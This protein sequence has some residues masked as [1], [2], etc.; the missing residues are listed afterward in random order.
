MN[1]H[2]LN[3]RSE[4]FIDDSLDSVDKRCFFLMCGKQPN[5]DSA[6]TID[7]SFNIFD[8]PG[9]KK[10]VTLA[11]C[12]DQIIIEYCNE[13]LK[14]LTDLG[15][16]YKL[17]F[18]YSDLKKAKGPSKKNKKRGLQTTIQYQT[19]LYTIRKLLLK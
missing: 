19:P 16:Q 18:N 2:Y 9:L 6:I 4:I 14:S 5:I 1:N 13:I 3:Q 8:E 17:A 10:K 15:L 7:I 12:L 11:V